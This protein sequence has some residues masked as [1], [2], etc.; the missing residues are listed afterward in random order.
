MSSAAPGQM[1][2][3]GTKHGAVAK[4]RRVRRIVV[5]ILLIL[6]LAFILLELPLPWPSQARANS[7]RVKIMP[8]GDSITYGVGSAAGGGYRL[9]LWNDLHA[10]GMAVDFVGSQQNGPASFDRHN[11]GHPGWKIDQISAKVVNWLRTYQP[12]I[13]L[14]HIGT[15]D[16]I[17]NDD[18][19]QAPA[20][21]SHL[22]D[23]I[24]TTLPNA[25][26]IV[27]QIIPLPRSAKLNAEVVTYN[28]AIPALI[29]ADQARRKH[30]Q[31]VDLYHAV[32]PNLLPD[33]IHPNEAA[34]ALMAK[35]WLN[36]LLPLLAPQ[37]AERV[38]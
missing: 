19:A 2:A 1:S 25:T 35:V 5:G 21:L 18:P 3:P 4:N 7:V 24:T 16:F 8:L 14:L 22:I 33:H 12:Q 31:Y 26:L 32:P 9:P 38:P 15:N 20:R 23:L 29:R 17:K 13:I 36:A 6:G 37:T 34:Y 11:E 10:R 28:A 30:V 27:A